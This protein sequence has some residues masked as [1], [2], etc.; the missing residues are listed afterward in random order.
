MVGVGAQDNLALAKDFLADTGIS[1]A[2]MLWSDSFDSWR[3]YEIN[4]NSDMW[5]L[6]AN[7]NR[8]GERFYKFDENYVEELLDTLA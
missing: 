7:G 1:S 8:V 2:T 3:H 6:D 5:L 4:N